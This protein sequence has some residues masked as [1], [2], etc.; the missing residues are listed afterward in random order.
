MIL[1]QPSARGLLSYRT[2]RFR[3]YTELRSKRLS[4]LLRFSDSQPGAALAFRLSPTSY[5][6]RVSMQEGY[7][8]VCERIL[9][10]GICKRCERL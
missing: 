9:R 10:Q 6:N 8:S 4:A 1:Y 5:A 2:V 3:R 7:V